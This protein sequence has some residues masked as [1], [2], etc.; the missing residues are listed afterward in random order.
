MPCSGQTS[1]SW[2]PRRTRDGNTVRTGGL[3]AP[4]GVGGPG[5]ALLSVVPWQMELQGTLS[6]LGLNVCGWH[7]PWRRPPQCC[8]EPGQEDVAVMVI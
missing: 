2:H 3:V 1:T 7:M 4:A 6:P 5:H 8:G